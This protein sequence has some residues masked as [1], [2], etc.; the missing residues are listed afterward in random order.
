[1]KLVLNTQNRTNRCLVPIYNS[2][3]FVTGYSER[4]LHQKRNAAFRFPIEMCD[5]AS[6]DVN[7]LAY[8][9]KLKILIRRDSIGCRPLLKF[10]KAGEKNS[11][12]SNTLSKL[13]L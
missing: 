1:M 7:F 8:V 9:L 13:D 5:V 12:F 3:R 4:R 10:Q 6:S 11:K 2:D